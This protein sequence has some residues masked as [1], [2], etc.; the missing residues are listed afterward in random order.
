MNMFLPAAARTKGARIGT[1]AVP[2]LGSPQ[3]PT[4]PKGYGVYR[5][6]VISVF[7]KSSPLNSSAAR[8]AL[9]QV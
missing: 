3:S 2:A 5:A 6:G 7:V 1:C 4:A 9:A 8:F